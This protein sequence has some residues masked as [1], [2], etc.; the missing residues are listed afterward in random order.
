MVDMSLCQSHCD[1]GNASVD[2]AKPV[3]AVP[4][5]ITSSLRIELPDVAIASMAAPSPHV[6]PGPSP[7]PPLSRHTVLRL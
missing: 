1:Y 6:A 3:H 7:P 4:V 5:A 2:A